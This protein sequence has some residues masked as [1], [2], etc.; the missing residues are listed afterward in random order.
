MEKVA[1]KLIIKK[2][3]SQNDLD[4]AFTIRKVVFVEEQNVP[5]HEEYDQF[6]ESSHHFLASN[7]EGI[8]LGTARWRKTE[9][10]IK[11]ERFAVLKEARGLGVGRLLVKAVLEDINKENLSSTLRYLNAQVSAISLY[12]KFGFETVGEEFLEC[13]IRHKRMELRL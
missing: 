10:G 5:T 2:I 8:P 4:K 11:M 9:E 12:E 7:E 6:E 1:R 13:D 3:T